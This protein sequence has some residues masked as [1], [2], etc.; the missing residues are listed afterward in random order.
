MALAQ[1]TIKTSGNPLEELSALLADDM[2]QTNAL[3]LRHL[4]SDVALIPQ[5]AAWL[6]AAGGKRIRPLLTIAAARLCGD[7]SACSYGLAAAVEFIHTAT[8]LHDDVVD[9]SEERRGKDSANVV[10][11]NQ[12]SVLVGDFL[13][14]RA[15]QLMVA[16][17]SLEVLRILSDASAVISEGEVMQL[18]TANNVATTMAQYEKVIAAKTAALFA[19]ACEIGPVVAGARKEVQE[20]MR[21]Y[22]HNLGM[23]FQIADDILDYT[24]DQKKLGKTVGDDF[25]EGKMTAPVIIALMQATADEKKFWIRTMAEKAQMPDD[26]PR[27]LE[28]FHRTG[29]L[30]RGIEMAW[31]YAG[32]AQERLARMDKNGALY[33]ALYGL[34]GFAVTRGH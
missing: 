29:A 3:I 10:F 20:A 19:A 14:S 26:L 30:D 21:G 24:A 18:Q 22:G 23:A 2:K 32:R 31:N 27:A 8:L 25:R 12:A 4:H 17:G 28:I 5:V 13:F 6:I 9:K 1:K 15:F 33:D 7:E 16:D 11:G 34:A